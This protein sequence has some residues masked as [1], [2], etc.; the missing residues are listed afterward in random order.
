M[1]LLAVSLTLLLSFSGL[2][3]LCLSMDRHGRTLFHGRPS[4]QR[5]LAFR[6]AGWLAIALAFAAA[7]VTA[8]WNF[9]PVQWLGSL[10][11]SALI[12]VALMSYRPAWIRPAAIAAL[13]LAMATAFFV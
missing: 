11:G 4:R 5:D 7:I 12:V 8:D 6:A 2:A 9:G 10:T 13:P 3:C 1:T